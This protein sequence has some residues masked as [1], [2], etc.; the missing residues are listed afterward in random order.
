[1]YTIAERRLNDPERRFGEQNQNSEQL[2]H[3]QTNIIVMALREV[4]ELEDE[5]DFDQ[6]S[7]QLLPCSASLHTEHPPPMPRRGRRKNAP[8][9]VDIQVSDTEEVVDEDPIVDIEEPEIAVD[10][11]DEDSESKDDELEDEEV[12]RSIFIV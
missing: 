6:T 10:D 5:R 2:S 7:G 8:R 11:E 12:R 4:D 9:V 1:M 3:C